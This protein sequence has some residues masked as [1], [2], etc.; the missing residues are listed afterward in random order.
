MTVLFNIRRTKSEEKLR[1]SISFGRGQQ[2]IFSSPFSCPH[3]KF[4]T[5][6]QR[7]KSKLEGVDALNAQI[8][9]VLYNVRS[10]L[11]Y[12]QN[13]SLEEL[14]PRIKEI[15][16]TSQYRSIN[17]F[18]GKRVGKV[19]PFAKTKKVNYRDLDFS[20]VRA[21]QKYQEDNKSVFQPETIRKYDILI[22][23]LEKAKMNDADIRSINTI[24]AINSG[25]T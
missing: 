6:T 11:Q 12:N 9:N 2:M 18:N 8:Q 20:V 25:N 14:K 5:K 4:D 10:L 19:S 3:G 22:T 1:L 23:L 21:I 16:N 13:V 15:L 7:I 24:G 17:I